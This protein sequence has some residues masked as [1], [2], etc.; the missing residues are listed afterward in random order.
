MDPLTSIAV[1]LWYGLQHGRRVRRAKELPTETLRQIVSHAHFLQCDIIERDAIKD[2][3]TPTER[4]ALKATE[5]VYWDWASRLP[6]AD[7]MK[8]EPDIPFI[9]AL[10]SEREAAGP[11]QASKT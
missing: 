11:P 5:L 8:D 2:S 9:E 3:L 6:R 4:K 1:A 7:S 10:L